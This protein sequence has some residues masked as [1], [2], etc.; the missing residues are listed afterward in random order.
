MI[1]FDVVVH[2]QSI[3]FSLCLRI[4][5]FVQWLKIKPIGPLRGSSM[6]KS[7]GHPGPAFA[8][9]TCNTLLMTHR[10]LDVL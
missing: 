9:P 10:I 5:I 8:F 2:L 1:V 7:V 3:L 6:Q 4:T